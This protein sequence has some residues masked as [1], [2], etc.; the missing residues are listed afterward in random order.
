MRAS[1]RCPGDRVRDGP[2]IPDRVTVRPVGRA[3]LRGVSLAECPRV[4]RAIS[5]GSPVPPEQQRVTPFSLAVS[6]GSLRDWDWQP[7]ALPNGQYVVPTILAA[8]MSAGAL[9]TPSNGSRLHSL[10]RCEGVTCWYMLLGSLAF[11]LAMQQLRASVP[12]T[13]PLVMI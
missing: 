5:I 8:C 3:P 9:C 13:H 12:T 7:S 1:L 4:R 6:R 10:K 2:P 11:G